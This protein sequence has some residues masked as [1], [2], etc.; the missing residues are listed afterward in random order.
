MKF[1]EKYGSVVHYP[2]ELSNRKICLAIPPTYSLGIFIK[3]FCN[4]CEFITKFSA[5]I[6]CAKELSVFNNCYPLK[7]LVE[8][9][10]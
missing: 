7:L 8:T 4:F 6:R 5:K 10:N 9:V 1:T 2:S 3:K